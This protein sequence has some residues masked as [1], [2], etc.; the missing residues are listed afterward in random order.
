MTKKFCAYTK[1]VLHI[2]GAQSNRLLIW[3]V[4]KEK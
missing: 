4:I 1:D 3:E 2:S